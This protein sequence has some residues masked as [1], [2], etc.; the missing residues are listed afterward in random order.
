MPPEIREAR[1]K[2]IEVRLP[3][4]RGG[5]T[6]F[7]FKAP[8]WENLAASANRLLKFEFPAIRDTKVFERLIKTNMISTGISKKTLE[9]LPLSALETIYR[10]LWQCWF[11]AAEI[12][13]D[14]WLT[15]FL[16]AEDLDAF[17][18]DELMQQD[19]EQLG[20]RD[21]GL[22]HR[23]YYDGPLTREHLITFLAGH[24]YRSDLLQAVGETDQAALSLAYFACRKL[25]HPFPW[26]QLLGSLTEGELTQ[27]PRLAYLK[28][29][30]QALAKQ[31]WA[32]ANVTVNNVQQH[33]KALNQWLNQDGF[34]AIGARFGLARPVQE[35]VIVEGET[36]KLLLP[37]F[38]EAMGLNLDTLGIALLPAG[39]KNHVLSIYRQQA[40]VLSPPIFIILDSDAQAI[41]EELQTDLRDQD[42]IFIIEQGEFED[43]YDL[44]LVLHTVNQHYQPYPEINRQGFAQI[45]EDNHAK[46]RV[47]ALKA[48]WQ[49]YN[50]GSFDKIEFAIHYREIFCQAQARPMPKL[51]PA[52]VQTLIERILSI[53]Q[54]SRRSG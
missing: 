28:T 11:G 31:P 38:A 48:V 35:L 25:T 7:S 37:V 21:P 50:L 39:G 16:L 24:G 41:A 26:T 52:P 14:Q 17:R 47:Q 13:A 2:T 19:I 3:D 18:L 5:E 40:R 10:T 15:L 32:Q 34:S 29:V 36:E 42:A 51:L 12:N 53:R 20:H 8:T 33:L 9:T 44:D 46:G 27:A 30:A 4:E 43:I 22:M 6:L 49:T 54:A 45:A 23:Y 1:Q